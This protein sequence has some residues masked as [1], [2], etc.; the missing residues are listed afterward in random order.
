MTPAL[1]RV[2]QAH[3]RSPGGEAVTAAAAEGP[4]NNIL[5]PDSSKMRKGHKSRKHDSHVSGPS[6]G[7]SDGG[8]P[9][10]P[11]TG[12][13]APGKGGADRATRRSVSSGNPAG[14]AARRD[15]QELDHWH[16]GP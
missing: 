9:V 11:D 6:G 1:I 4:L 5:L 16:G 10:S 7:P 3:G 2:S 15:L 8:R 12:G 14:S 13:P